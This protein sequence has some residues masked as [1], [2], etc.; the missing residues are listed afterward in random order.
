MNIRLDFNTKLSSTLSSKPVFKNVRK[1]YGSQCT[2][3]KSM[4]YQVGKSC[5]V[6][7]SLSFMVAFMIMPIV[8]AFGVTLSA[9]KLT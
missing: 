8:S 9:T 1:Y 4:V 3:G 7:L 6:L 5:F 2:S